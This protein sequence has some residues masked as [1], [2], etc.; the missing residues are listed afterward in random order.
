MAKSAD[1][2]DLKSFVPNGTCGF[3]SRPG[4]QQEPRF[5]GLSAPQ[6][7]ER[8]FDVA[9]RATPQAT[10]N[11]GTPRRDEAPHRDGGG[12]RFVKITA[13]VALR[14]VVHEICYTFGARARRYVE[15]PSCGEPPGL[16]NAAKA[17]FTRDSAAAV[18]TTTTTSAAIGLSRTVPTTT[19]GKSQERKSPGSTRSRSAPAANSKN[20]TPEPCGSLSTSPSRTKT[21]TPRT[22]TYLTSNFAQPTES[23]TA[24]RSSQ[25]PSAI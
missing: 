11:T 20:P 21:S 7:G 23:P 14:E 8:L 19:K 2:K 4:H 15:T 25:T 12:L 1:A 5:A 3:N 16:V 6:Q 9:W 17:P 22:R 10:D 18:P 13:G 24:S